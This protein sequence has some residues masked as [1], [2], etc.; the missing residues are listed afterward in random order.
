MGRSPVMEKTWD[1]N[2]L[3]FSITTSDKI[4][5]RHRRDHD[6]QRVATTIEGEIHESQ[7][8]KLRIISQGENQEIAVKIVNLLHR[9]KWIFL[10]QMLVVAIA[11]SPNQ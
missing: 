2:E 9:H 10:H 4:R 7:Q 8:Q 3:S 6:R 11:F 1:E 5:D